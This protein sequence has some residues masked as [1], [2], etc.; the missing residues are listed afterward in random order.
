MAADSAGAASPRVPAGVVAGVALV[1]LCTLFFEVLLTRIFSVTLW[2]HFGF[3]AISLAMLGTAA[4]AV[5]CYLYPERLAGK[6]HLRNMALAAAV[7]AVATPAAVVYH[8]TLRLPGFDPPW[9]FYLAFG[10]Q[11]ALLFVAFFSGG[12]CI[13]IGLFRYASRIG[14]VYAFDLVGASL[15]AVL[16]VPLLYQWSPM[17]LS[18]LVAAAAFGAAFALARSGAAR[19]STQALLLVAVAAGLGL[20]AANDRWGLVTVESVKSYGRG[21]SQK[22]EPQSLYE[23]WSPVSRVAV[24]ES[25][26][27]WASAPV[28]MATTDAGAPTVLFEFDGHYAGARWTFSRDSTLSVFRLK[29]DAEV[30]VVGAGGGRDVLAALAY[31]HRKVTAVE[32][33]PLMGDV[34]LRAFADHIGRIFEDPRVTLHIQDGRSFVAGSSERYDIIEFSMIDSWSS[35]AAAGA[36]VFNENSLYTLDAIDDFMA[37]LE[38]GGILSMTRYYSWGE[39]LRVASLFTAWLDSQG[40]EDADR[41]IVAIMNRMPRPNATVMLKK[42]RFTREEAAKLVEIA[43]ESDSRI[44]HA[45]HLAPEKLAPLRLRKAFRILVN[46]QGAGSSRERFIES[47]PRDISPPSDDRPFFFYTQRWR[48]ALRVDSREHA[49]R[50]LALPLLFGTTLALGGISAITIFLPLYLRSDAALRRAP[51]RLRG[52]GY[53][54]MLGAGFMLVEIS[55]IQRLTVFLGHPTWSFVVVLATILFSSGL[56]SRF[57]ARWEGSEPRVLRRVLLGVAALLLL[58]ALVVYDGFIEL[59]ALDQRARIALSVV[60]VALPGFLMGMCFPM[61]IQIVRR[62]HANLVPWGW[63]VNGA[64]SVF[65]SVL[66]IVLALVLGF[67]ATLLVGTACYV[68]AYLLVRTVPGHPVA[69]ERPL[70]QVP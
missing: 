62:L 66:S 36:Y 5:L 52:M 70:E 30:L 59:M 53:F 28:L 19:V 13:S 31:G 38:P 14:I 23:R 10:S 55:L 39:A 6:R 22:S 58:Y 61:G 41:R 64:F 40:L 17:A 44:L 48:D 20:A 3:L 33:N 37:H 47:H 63:G 12:L 21:E 43:E 35:A 32:I 60:A 15:G 25:Q 4:S 26:P 69:E 68:V 50:R 1:A 7:F 57:S 8:V 2:Y 11:L 24:Q 51:F 45:P 18:F 42:G 9:L 27:S 49:A 16:V 46:P 34:V 67:R 56:G 29:D 65:A 54:A